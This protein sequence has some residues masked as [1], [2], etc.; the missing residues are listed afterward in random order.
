MRKLCVKRCDI[1]TKAG[2]R[3]WAAFLGASKKRHGRN[4]EKRYTV[5][6]F[7]RRVLKS[8]GSR[9][10]M[11]HFIWRA[12]LGEMEKKSRFRLVFKGFPKREIWSPP[13]RKIK[14]FRRP[15]FLAAT[16]DRFGLHFKGFPQRDGRSARRRKTK[17]F[18]RTPSF[19]CGRNG[20]PCNRRSPGIK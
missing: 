3:F 14:T 19:C 8:V 4:V 10:H 18:R 6:S 15:C 5:G 11:F 20:R 13:R 17:G 16:E 7:R 1:S 9:S 12:V 2:Q